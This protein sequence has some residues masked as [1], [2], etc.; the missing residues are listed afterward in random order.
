MRRQRG[1]EPWKAP[2]PEFIEVLYEK[3]FGRPRPD[4]ELSIEQI[5]K[6]QAA[7]KAEKKA[8]KA[9]RRA[10]RAAQTNVVAGISL[11]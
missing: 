1:V 4:E 8:A 5:A 6:R 10:A 7:K 11:K 9:E 2:L 3:R